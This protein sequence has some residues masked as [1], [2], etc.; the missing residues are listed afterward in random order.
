MNKYLAFP[1]FL[2]VMALMFALTFG[3]VGSFL[4]TLMDALVNNVLGAAASAAH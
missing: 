1:I 3:P 2:A 4:T